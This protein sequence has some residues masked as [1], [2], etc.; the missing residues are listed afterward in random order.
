MRGRDIIDLKDFDKK[1]EDIFLPLV[2]ITGEWADTKR[3]LLW[4][5]LGYETLGI[6]Y[7]KSLLRAVP[8]TWTEMQSLAIQSEGKSI[9][10]TNLWLGPA[11]NPNTT[12]TI[13]YFMGK[14]GSRSS[15]QI[16]SGHSGIEEYTSYASLPATSGTGEGEISPS[17]ETLGNMKNE[18]DTSL[19]T[20]V[21]LFMRGRIAL[22]VG[23]PS[24]IREIE[25]SG[26]RAESELLDDLILTE[27]LP[28][29]SLGKNRVNIAKYRYLAISKKTEKAEASARLLSY[30]MSDLWILRAQEAF[31]LLISPL[32]SASEW[33]KQTSLS[34]VYART[35]LDAFIPDL[36]DEIFVY[37]YWVKIEYEK[38]FRD[39]IDRSE[40]ID[41][42][43]L[44]K[45]LDKNIFCELE[46]MSGWQLSD[47]CISGDN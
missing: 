19:L 46:S 38:I 21:D 24:I 32:R 10:A 42:N 35:K 4:V 22:F 16:Q 39:Y 28:Q 6:F 2:Q 41:T 30:L 9:F 14:N 33:Q 12:D 3:S 43:N 5:P 11:Y 36:Q 15:K 26:K 47:R 13:A 34:K 8:K 37:N 17:S 25:K 44:I 1:Y 27:K 20:T 7:H 40:K 29:D 18:L 23:Y 31:P 45:T